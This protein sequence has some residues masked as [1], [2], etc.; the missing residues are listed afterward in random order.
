MKKRSI[1]SKPAQNQDKSKRHKPILKIQSLG[2][3]IHL[4]LLY[5]KLFVL[6]STISK[7][8]TFPFFKYDIY[9][10][11]WFK[12]LIYGQCLEELLAQREYSI[13]KAAINVV[14]ITIT[15]I[16][17]SFWDLYMNCSIYINLSEVKFQ[18]A[19]LWLQLLRVRKL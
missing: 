9:L 12:R 10:T 7:F 6:I 8:L 15:I 18:T 11:G 3:F 17:S 2:H 4:K 14:I 16:P 1:S 19:G 13:S 5:H